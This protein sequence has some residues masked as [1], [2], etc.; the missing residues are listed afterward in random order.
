MS[1]RT[2]H[3]AG[4]PH[5]G[6]FRTIYEGDKISL[7]GALYVESPHNPCLFIF[8]LKPKSTTMTA[9]ECFDTV[10]KVRN[11]NEK[12]VTEKI[13]TGIMKAVQSNDLYFTYDG[14]IS[15]RLTTQLQE[16]GFKVS[17][18]YQHS[19]TFTSISWDLS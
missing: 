4:G 8:Q 12:Q 18:G 5:D 10:M 11:T 9:Q 15:D 16:A 14:T 19:E 7:N 6:Q 13:Y 17:V 1:Y 3:L 2:I